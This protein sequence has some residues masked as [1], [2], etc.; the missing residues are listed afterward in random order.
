MTLGQRIQQLRKEKG[1]SQEALGD[2]LGVS[3]QAISKWESDLTIPEIDNLIAMS[4]L[5]NTPVGVLLGVEEENPGSPAAE[6]L[7]DRELEAIEAIVSRYLEKAQQQKPK[8][9][10]WPIVVSLIVVLFLVFWFKGQLENLNGRM[11]SLQNNVNNISNNVSYEINS[12]TNQIQT[13][14]EQEASL[15]ADYSYEVASVDI[16]NETLLL[17][18]QVTPKQ[19]TE[20]MEMIF[21][22]ES[23]EGE[24][25]T[26]SGSLTPGH[27]FL[28]KGFEVPLSNEIKLSVTFGIDGNWQTQALE[29]L[30]GWKRN[31]QLNLDLERGGQ[32]YLSVATSNQGLWTVKWTLNG[33]FTTFME[34]GLKPETA[35]LHLSKNGS[36]L[37]SIPLNLI[38]K[39]DTVYFE[40]NDYEKNTAVTFGDVLEYGISYTDNFGRELFYSIECVEFQKSKSGHLQEVFVAL[41]DDVFGSVYEKI[42]E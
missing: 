3:R 26:A 34:A 5:F 39:G 27:T 8:R 17:D 32:S 41:A 29:T 21:T 6:E 14:L 33:Y 37:E 24:T 25:V 28:A 11:S 4:K 12:M 20:G 38:D 9:K 15:L 18:V 19:Y 22:A 16:A 31:S 30:Q 42:F 7:T 2:A 36:V 13:I 40:V 35:E 1:L 23:A 10:I